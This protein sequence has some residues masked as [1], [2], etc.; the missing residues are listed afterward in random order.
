M[1]CF[2]RA[3]ARWRGYPDLAEEALDAV[4][5]YIGLP[6]DEA[7]DLAF[8]LGRDVRL[9]ASAFKVIPDGATI[10]ALSASMPIGSG[11]SSSM[12]SVKS[13]PRPGCRPACPRQICVL[14][15]SRL[16]RLLLI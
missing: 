8:R 11:A 2:R 1:I 5:V 6:A 4:V 14:A 12:R 9:D 16:G 7:L 13:C 3:S 10:M 15:P